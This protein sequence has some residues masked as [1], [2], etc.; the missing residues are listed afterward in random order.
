MVIFIKYPRDAC[1]GSHN[2][3][4]RLIF[5][6]SEKYILLFRALMLCAIIT[7]RLIILKDRAFLY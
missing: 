6:C 3:K 1:Y 4:T 5:H 7:L 2:L